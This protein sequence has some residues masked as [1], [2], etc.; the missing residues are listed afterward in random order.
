ML[1][2]ANFDVILIESVGLGQSEVDI[3]IAV[4][5]V[6]IV[7][8]PGSGDGLQA[9]KKGIMEA[10]DLVLVNKADGHLLDAAKHTK[11]DYSGA[12]H[13]IRQKH[14]DWRASV[15]LMSASTGLG[16]AEVEQ[17]LREFHTIMSKNG[18]LIQ[19]RSNQYEAWMWNQ[20]RRQLI[21]RAEKSIAVRD[22]ASH[23]LAKVRAQKISPS[24]AAGEMLTS[25]LNDKIVDDD[26]NNH[27]V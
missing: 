4:D 23:V 20:F 27:T 18:S 25:F 5:M 3:D 13:F 11:A 26:H 12:M 21:D 2:S 15:M 14:K 9:S 6:I 8:P 1:P 19:K 24:F 22:K 10:A 17:K 16:M 7:V